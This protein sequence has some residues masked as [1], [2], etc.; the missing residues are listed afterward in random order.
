MIDAHIAFLDRFGK[1]TDLHLIEALVRT[2]QV[3]MGHSF[4][5]PNMLIDF[6]ALYKSE[7]LPVDMA[8]IA[9]GSDCFLLCCSTSC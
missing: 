7:F 6:N 9:I 3:G 5:D 1:L 4:D 8:T 2:T